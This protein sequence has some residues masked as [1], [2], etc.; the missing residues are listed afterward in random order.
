MI[1]TQVLL[2]YVCQ[3]MRPQDK[4]LLDVSSNGSLAKYKM[5]DR[6]QGQVSVRNFTQNEFVNS[7]ASNR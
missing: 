2:S 4:T 5:A 6:S 7:I 1:D 3:G